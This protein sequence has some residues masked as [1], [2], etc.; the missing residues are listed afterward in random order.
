M[1]QPSLDTLQI[2]ETTN[3]TKSQKIDKLFIFLVRGENRSVPG[4]SLSEPSSEPINSVQIWRR[5]R[6][7]NPGHTGG[8][9]V[10]SPLH[11]TLLSSF[12]N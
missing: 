11:Q 12:V 2:E 8:R 6:E 1:Y 4:K 10:L 5:D 9:R 7:S 3:Q